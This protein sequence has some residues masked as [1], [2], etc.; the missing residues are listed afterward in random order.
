MDF[1]IPSSGFDQQSISGGKSEAKAPAV[2]TSDSNLPPEVHGSETDDRMS[3]H[4][5]VM[6][7]HTEFQWHGFDLDFFSEIVDTGAFGVVKLL[8]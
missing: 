2:P 5:K 1:I 3:Q 6:K 7:N 4:S 8:Y